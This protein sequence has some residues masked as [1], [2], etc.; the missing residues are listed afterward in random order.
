MFEDICGLSCVEN[1]VLAI[2]KQRD[3]DV[4]P[5][6]HNSAMPLKEIFFYMVIL[7]KKQEYFDRLPRIQKILKKLDII[8][9]ELLNE[10][11]IKKVR[12]EIRKCKDNEYVLLKIEPVH[13][14]EKLS[15]RG[16][17]ND[18]FVLVRAINEKFELI[19]DIPEKIILLT[20]RQLTEFYGG[21]YFKLTVNREIS[22]DDIKT[23]WRQRKFKPEKYTPFYF[24]EGDFDGIPDIGIRLRNMTGILK[25][26]RHRLAEYYK[27]YVD[28]DFIKLKMPSIEKTYSTFEYYNL[29]KNTSFAKYYDLFIELNRIDICIMEEL[30]CRLEENKIVER[31]DKSNIIRVK[32][33]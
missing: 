26:L 28:T 2:L 22:A 25:L 4:S 5:L 18:H 30:K 31:K 19:N 33:D 10:P 29:K 21:E 6:Y 1:Q 7:G 17:R 9:M 14:K 8:S 13:V 20:A 12:K 23:L 3:M 11:M 15:A 32:F 24:C 27:N 16:L